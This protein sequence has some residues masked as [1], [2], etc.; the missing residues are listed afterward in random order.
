MGTEIKRYAILFNPS[1]PEM[2]LVAAEH[3]SMTRE[4]QPL[5]LD[6]MKFDAVY[7]LDDECRKVDVRPE[8]VC[9]PPTAASLQKVVK[10]LK[11]RHMIDSNAFIYTSVLGH[12][13]PNSLGGMVRARDFAKVLNEIPA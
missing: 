5:L 11:E 13:G 8:V 9:L 2:D 10:E 7:R 4:L 1:L 6:K 12:G 3:R